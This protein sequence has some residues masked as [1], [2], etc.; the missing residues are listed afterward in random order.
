ML[1]KEEIKKI[2]PQ[3]EP[4]LLVDEVEEY[5]PGQYCIAYKEITES[6][7]AMPEITYDFVEVVVTASLGFFKENTSFALP[8]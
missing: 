6:G 2:I 8:E 4:F 1:N 3:R 7:C 5:I